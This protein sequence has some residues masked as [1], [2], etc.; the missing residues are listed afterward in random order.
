MSRPGLEIT[1]W[2]VAL[3][4]MRNGRDAGLIAAYLDEEAR[5]A[6]IDPR[7]LSMHPSDCV[8][9]AVRRAVELMRHLAAPIR[10]AMDAATRMQQATT[11][12][13]FTL[14]GPP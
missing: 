10:E 11:Q 13:D 3:G 8:A 14:A 6:G 2:A 9:R 1:P 12:A 5:R 7:D 4:M